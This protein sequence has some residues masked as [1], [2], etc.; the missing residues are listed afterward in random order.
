[1]YII[2]LVDFIGGGRICIGR[3]RLLMKLHR[4]ANFEGMIG[5]EL[6]RDLALCE[7]AD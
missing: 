5:L 2:L 6:G 4:D 1:L 3:F 7:R